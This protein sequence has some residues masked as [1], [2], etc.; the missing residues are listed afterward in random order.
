MAASPHLA[1]SMGNDFIPRTGGLCSCVTESRVAGRTP[2]TSEQTGQRHSSITPLNDIALAMDFRSLDRM[3]DSDESIL[4]EPYRP[5]YNIFASKPV[6][7]KQYAT[8]LLTIEPTDDFARDNDYDRATFRE[9]PLLGVL[10]FDNVASEA[11]DIAANERSMHG[12]M[13]K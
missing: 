8:L 2:L 10:L 4:D 5:F 3:G 1:R 11:R 13:I 7:V 6:L 9:R 12:I